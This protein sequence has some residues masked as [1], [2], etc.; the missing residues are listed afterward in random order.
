MAFSSGSFINNQL[1]QIFSTLRSKPLVGTDLHVWRASLNSS[2]AELLYFQSLLSKEENERAARFYFERDRGRYIAGRGILRTLLGGYL[3][4]DAHRIKIIYGPDGKPMLEDTF[5]K[6]RLQFNLS[7]SND[8]AIYIFGWDHPV[9]IDLEHVR[10][11]DAADDFAKQYFAAQETALL[12]SL[13]HDQKWDAFFKFWTAK[14]S[15]LKAKGSG[16]TFPL[17]QVEISLGAGNDARI[18]SINGDLQQAANWRLETFI[19]IAGYQAAIAVEKNQG[20]I[21]FQN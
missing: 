9:G 16:L 6:R 15:F 13:T 1:G 12:N 17:N 7:N 5:N 4:M 2:S 11:F 10:V 21:L 8:W 14:E 19:P 18:A 20:R 3:G